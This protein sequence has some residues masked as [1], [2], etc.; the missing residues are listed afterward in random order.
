MNDVTSLIL[1]RMR[2]PLILIVLVYSI[3]ILGLILIPGV[4]DKGNVWYMSIFHAFYFVSF[5]ATTIGFG[6][7]PYPLTDAQRL[8]T[9]FIIYLTVIAWFYALGT[10]VSLIQDSTFRSVV[11]KSSFRRDVKNIHRPYYVVCGYGETGK[12]VVNALLEEHF[13]AVVIELKDD[14]SAHGLS[15]TLE[16]V[17]S[18]TADAADPSTLELAGVHLSKCRG[19][20]AVTASDETNLKIAIISKLLH[21]NVTVIC[22]SE[23]KEYEQNMLSFGTD[24]IINPFESFANILSMALHSPSMHLIYDWLTGAPN[25]SLSTPLHVSSGHWILSGYG[26]FGQKVHQEL[27]NKDIRTVII[28]PDISTKKLLA[29]NSGDEFI[30]GTGTDAK[31][32]TAA[33]IENAAGI[34]A[35]TDNDSNNL[36][37]IMTAR[38]LNKQVFVVGRQNYKTNELLYSKINEHYQR[39]THKHDKE[40]NTIAHL[41]MQPSEIIARRIRSI[42]IAPLLI[43]FIR[44]ALNESQEWANIT[45]SRLSAVI[46]EDSPH[47]WT[48]GITKDKAPA[49]VQALAYGR[50]IQLEHIIQDPVSNLRDLPCVALV[51]KRGESIQLLPDDNTELKA[52]DQILFC[53]LRKVKNSMNSTIS[54]MSALNYVMTFQNE[55]QSYLWKKITRLLKKQDR[56]TSSRQNRR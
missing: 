2:R 47:L 30:I 49:I 35:G 51:L 14:I 43:D 27:L 46:G 18:I 56:R 55:P 28:D 42:L 37:I 33:G 13:G 10:V 1:R 29:S 11:K 53:G 15:D 20:I 32:L 3:A 6:E 48:I 8:W 24:H 34:I 39:D 5:T 44:L 25:I 40:L 9:V 16:Y 38:Q 21:P 7:I 12:A 31:T 17:P 45:I 26:R 50:R 36:S 41:V 54:D 4:D 23:Y 19:V 22:R 52:F